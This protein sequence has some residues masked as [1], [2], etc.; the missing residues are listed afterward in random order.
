M[1]GRLECPMLCTFMFLMASDLTGPHYCP[2][3]TDSGQNP[4]AG[5]RG[6]AWW[7]QR[8]S[9]DSKGCGAP[10]WG[11]RFVQG[12]RDCH[13][14][15]HSSPRSELTHSPLALS[16]AL[17]SLFWCLPCS[18]NLEA[19]CSSIDLTRKVLCGRHTVDNMRPGHLYHDHRASEGVMALYDYI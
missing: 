5:H 12:F 15:H 4:A 7:Y 6:Y 2:L 13:H 8:C 1:R 11:S 9:T 19:I 17:H 14:R 16:A 3:P 18:L 10:R